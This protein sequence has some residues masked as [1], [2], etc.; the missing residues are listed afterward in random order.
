MPGKGIK[1]EPNGRIL[2]TKANAPHRG[3][4]QTGPSGG[5]VPAPLDWQPGQQLN[6]ERFAVSSL[7]Q[8]CAQISPEVGT[9]RV[10]PRGHSDASFS[11]R[12]TFGPGSSSR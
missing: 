1:G 6:P 12:S 2:A 10:E 7:G 11:A 3:S 4:E 9:V 5:Q 8:S